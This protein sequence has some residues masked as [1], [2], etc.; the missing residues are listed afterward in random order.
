MADREVSWGD[1]VEV[2]VAAPIIKKGKEPL[3]VP[4]WSVDTRG[5]LPIE[6]VV[7]AA[8]VAEAV[9]SSEPAWPEEEKH[10]NERGYERNGNNGNFSERNG[11]FNERNGNFTERNERGFDRGER[12][13]RGYERNDRNSRNERGFERG[14]ERNDRGERGFERNERG[15]DRGN[16]RRP[17]RARLDDLSTLNLPGVDLSKMPQATTRLSFSNDRPKRE[18]R[19]NDDRRDVY[20]RVDR[21]TR[22]VEQMGWGNEEE[23]K[24]TEELSWGEEPASEPVV[25]RVSERVCEPVPVYKPQAAPVAT[26]VKIA[27]STGRLEDDGWGDEPEEEIVVKVA[28]P[29]KVVE[30]VKPVETVKVAEPVKTPEA[31]KPVQPVKPVTPAFP[32]S[33][34]APATPTLANSGSSEQVAQWPHGHPAMMMPPYAQMAPYMMNPMSPPPVAPMSMMPGM[35]MPIW[36][37]C[38][39]CY[40]CYMYPPVA[41]GAGPA[42]GA[43]IASAPPTNYQN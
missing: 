14:F 6:Q 3:P 7:T 16:E 10:D 29:V 11:N 34:A 4:E 17:G 20:E 38:P 40:H 19:Q 27:I 2:E 15:N 31:P 21:V 8:A 43:Q 39:F 1:E 25:E 23:P 9:E 5:D 36:V 22:E 18:S 42:P 37:T 41:P 32:V 26:P 33:P 13:D 24:S 12:S 30:P 35:M 28:E